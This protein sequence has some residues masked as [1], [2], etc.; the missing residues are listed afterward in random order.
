MQSVTCLTADL[1][2]ATSILTQYHTFMETDHKIISTAISLWLIQE[3]L[4]SVLSENM[5]EKLIN[6][7]VK[8]AQEKYVVTCTDRHDMTIAFDCEVKH[9]TK[10][11]EQ[12]HM[13][14]IAMDFF[15]HLLK[16]T[17]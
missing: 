11:T 1:S 9:Q 13:L 14:K 15:S 10:Q 7:F 3:G 6:G 16:S 2:V 8:L 4:L 12:T 5:C 17:C